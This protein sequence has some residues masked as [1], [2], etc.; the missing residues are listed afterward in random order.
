M[1]SN[2]ASSGGLQTEFAP[3]WWRQSRREKNMPLGI[4]LGITQG[5][6]GCCYGEQDGIHFKWPLTGAI[7]SRYERRT[8]GTFQENRGSTE[9]FE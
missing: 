4:R 3:G 8:T 7:L 9:D 6:K 1:M 2:T 5:S